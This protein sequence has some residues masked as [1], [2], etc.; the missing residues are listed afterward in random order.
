MAATSSSTSS[1]TRS[2]RRRAVARVIGPKGLKGGLRVEPL[3]DWPERLAAGEELWL[4]DSSEPMGVIRVEGGGRVPVVYLDTVDSREA[5]EALVGRYLE[6][7]ARPLPEG[8]Y[9]WDQLI[10]LEVVEPDGAA[11]GELVEI[12][13]AGGNEVYRVVDAAGG[14]RLVPALRTSVL[15]IDL[16][17]GRMTVAPDEAEEVG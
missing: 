15:D 9:Y 11:V 6:A 4:D 3:T 16:A 8:E 14:E 10:G 5:A 2:D 13:R 17:A 12:F 7:P 1:P